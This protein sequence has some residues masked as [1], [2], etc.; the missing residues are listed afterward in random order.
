[1]N[2][3]HNA[4]K[5]AMVAVVMMAAALT[6][7]V[8][9]AQPAMQGKFSLPC[10]TYWGDAVLPAG[11]YSFTVTKANSQVDIIRVH[12]AVNVQHVN[13]RQNES[14]SEASSLTLAK[15]NGV[16]I[17]RTLYLSEIGRSFRLPQAGAAKELLAKSQPPTIE[18][19]KVSITAGE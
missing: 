17:A 18:L 14:R 10:T 15:S 3:K 16:A 13:I 12:G 19:I 2:T 11:E 6:P 5:V 7:S 9:S 8:A 1:M 4:A